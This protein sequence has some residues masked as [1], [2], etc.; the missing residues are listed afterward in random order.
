MAEL[1]KSPGSVVYCNGSDSCKTVSRLVRDHQPLQKFYR[2]GLLSTALSSESSK[3]QIRLPPCST[4]IIPPVRVSL[5]SSCSR[6][7]WTLARISLYV[8]S[9]SSLLPKTCAGS[10]RADAA[11]SWNVWFPATSWPA[12]EVEGVRECGGVRVCPLKSKVRGN[13][14]PP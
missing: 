8:S 10:S 14:V 11:N 3:P 7:G 9:A 12:Q 6:P 13:F 5:G 2:E 4:T 1:M